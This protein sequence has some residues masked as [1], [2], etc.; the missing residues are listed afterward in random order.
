MESRRKV[1]KKSSIFGKRSGEKG[2]MTG[3]QRRTSTEV[4]VPPERRLQGGHSLGDLFLSSRLSKGELEEEPEVSLVF[5]TRNTAREG[6]FQTT[7]G[8]NFSKKKIM[9]KN[10]G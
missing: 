2:G 7:V 4:G 3:K 5:L 10:V 6:R 8:K 1:L 9:R